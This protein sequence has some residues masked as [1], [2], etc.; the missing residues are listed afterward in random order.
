MNT[1]S[2]WKE[3]WLKQRDWYEPATEPR[4][5]VKEPRKKTRA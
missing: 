2:R 1:A 4:K 5:N 3:K